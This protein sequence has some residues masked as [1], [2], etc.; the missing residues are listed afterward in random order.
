MET[1]PLQG[2]YSSESDQED[3]PVHRRSSSA[4]GVP[5]DSKSLLEQ[6]APLEETRHSSFSS[7]GRVSK[8][9]T[10]KREKIE[11]IFEKLLDDNESVPITLTKQNTIRPQPRNK[12]SSFL[13]RIAGKSSGEQTA[14]V[15]TS[16]PVAP[17]IDPAL[18]EEQEKQIQ[19]RKEQVAAILERL[20]SSEID[21]ERVKKKK[22]KKK[23]RRSS[24]P[25][26]LPRQETLD[27]DDPRVQEASFS[28]TDSLL[29]YHV[30][31]HPG[32]VTPLKASAA[33]AARALFPIADDRTVGE[34]A[35]PPPRRLNVPETES[36]PESP[37]AQRKFVPF[38]KK[39]DP[40][41][42]SDFDWT[43]PTPLASPSVIAGMSE[44]ELKALQAFT[45]PEGGL[46]GEHSAETLREMAKFHKQETLKDS[47]ILNSLVEFAEE[48]EKQKHKSSPKIN[49]EEDLYS[50]GEIEEKIPEKQV[51]EIPEAVKEQENKP[52]QP[53]ETEPAKAPAPQ[54]SQVSIRPGSSI[55][56]AAMEF[57]A[58]REAQ[59]SSTEPSPQKPQ[60]PNPPIQERPSPI[61]EEEAKDI[62][63][64][65]P[66]LQNQMGKPPVPP[67]SESESKNEQKMRE[68]SSF[69]PQKMT[70]SRVERARS[71]GGSYD[72][73][74]TPLFGK[75]GLEPQNSVKTGTNSSTYWKELA[76][77]VPSIVGDK[78][79]KAGKWAVEVKDNL[80]SRYNAVPQDVLEEPPKKKVWLPGDSG[81][82][83]K[84]RK[85]SI[86]DWICDWRLIILLGVLFL[87]LTAILAAMMHAPSKKSIEATVDVK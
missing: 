67:K 50:G 81:D 34:M 55:A 83:P 26:D 25:K 73:E 23:G 85:F 71:T 76:G 51:E 79:S 64:D 16:Q 3:R 61:K 58:K 2:S 5:S 29:S 39:D 35:N 1:V 20:S 66:F 63:E 42:D 44:Y 82:D 8:L 45:A 33:A 56:K 46:L 52:D 48:E 87:I 65:S 86:V 60:R 47:E 72:L 24:I 32:R 69:V 18:L 13:S 9:P 75:N 36:D 28:D 74:N 22:Y 54:K 78:L 31:V 37:G 6:E 80:V 12:L 21:Q 10:K 77:K 11:S 19:K 40:N 53:V 41:S 27:R 84:K 30:A 57:L 68:I 38:R 15:T 17:P 14:T 7:A 59:I 49:T 62:A 4:G 70:I 43:K